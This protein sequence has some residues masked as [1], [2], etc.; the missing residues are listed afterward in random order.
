MISNFSHGVLEV[1]IDSLIDSCRMLGG[2]MSK[3]SNRDCIKKTQNSE[4]FIWFVIIVIFC[5]GGVAL[6]LLLFIGQEGPC[7]LSTLTRKIKI[8]SVLLWLT[9]ISVRWRI[10]VGP[11]W[12]IPNLMFRIP[13]TT[14]G[15]NL[16]CPKKIAPNCLSHIE[17]WRFE[18]WFHVDQ[19]RFAS[20][21]KSPEQRPFGPKKHRGVT[22]FPWKVAVHG[23]VVSWC[24]HVYWLGHVGTR[25][26]GFGDQ[27]WE[28]LHELVDRK[29]WKCS[30]KWEVY[31]R[32]TWSDVNGSP[33]FAVKRWAR[34]PTWIAC[35][36]FFLHQNIQSPTRGNIAKLG[37][38]NLSHA[39]IWNKPNPAPKGK[40][41]KHS[42]CSNQPY[43]G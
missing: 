37:G 6:T 36:G 3:L 22:R 11:K 21:K 27:N 15:P 13:A 18:R 28:R 1:L 31:S 4:G 12:F 41:H 24:S 32:L 10:R 9:P 39:S 16:R 40:C 17:S 26:K 30:K 19:L 7:F 34:I 14:I 38:K 29:L 25:L 2:L 20:D 8:A 5:A 23:L 42:E 43:V 33:I 35:F